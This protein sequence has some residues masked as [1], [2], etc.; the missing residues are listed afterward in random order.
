MGRTVI[1]SVLLGQ[2]LTWQT[3]PPVAPLGR[4]R[5]G[6]ACCWLLG[7]GP[8]WA[9]SCW[10]GEMEEKIEEIFLC[11]TC[12]TSR[13]DKTMRQNAPCSDAPPGGVPEEFPVV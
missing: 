8:K 10:R 11:A 4:C 9:G 12:Q 3:P 7:R 2:A 1:S 13:R 5:V 6:G